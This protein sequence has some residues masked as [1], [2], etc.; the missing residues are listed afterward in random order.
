MDIAQR[1]IDICIVALELNGDNQN[2]AM[3]WLFEKADDFIASGGLKNKKDTKKDPRAEKT[4]TLVQMTQFPSWLCEKALELSDNNAERAYEWLAG[5]NGSRYMKLYKQNENN[6]SKNGRKKR[7]NFDDG[8]AI[9]DMVEN[10]API[11]DSSSQRAVVDKKGTQIEERRR[12]GPSPSYFK[13]IY[14]KRQI[15]DSR[16][17]SNY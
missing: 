6:S 7:T 12:R 15:R 4:M 11:A 17:L 10:E 2:F 1:G 5:E 16:I 9:D 14:C 3:Q 13:E 8:A